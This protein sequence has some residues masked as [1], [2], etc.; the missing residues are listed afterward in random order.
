MK[1]VV[2]GLLL[3]V[4]SLLSPLGVVYAGWDDA[5]CSDPNISQAQKEAAMC[6]TTTKAPDLAVNL[7][8]IIIG[9]LGVV[10][11][12][13]IIVSGYRYVTAQGKPE[14]VAKARMAL[15][16]S[17]IGLIVAILAFAIVNFVSNSI[18]S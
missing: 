2:I 6:D 8:S 3:L 18:F 4:I 17:V 5:I 9:V 15:I 11:V 16:F 14:V 1:K 7:I 13:A 10:A 12:G